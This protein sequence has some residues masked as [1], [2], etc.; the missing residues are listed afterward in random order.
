MA[1]V[2]RFKG[3]ITN[4]YV[5]TVYAPAFNS[6]ECSKDYFYAQLQATTE[7]IEFR[8]VSFVA[9][10]PNPRIGLANEWMY[11]TMG[12]YALRQGCENDKPLLSFAEFNQVVVINTCF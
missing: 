6:W 10:D 8:D 1:N 12:K 11:H 2:A 4:I 3:G 7:R 5:I 9:G